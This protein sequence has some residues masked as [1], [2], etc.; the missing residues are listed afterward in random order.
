[1]NLIVHYYIAISVSYVW[2]V[3][4][5]KI[6]TTEIQILIMKTHYNLGLN[7]GMDQQQDHFKNAVQS[8]T[9]FFIWLNHLKKMGSVLNRPQNGPS[10]L[11]W[12]KKVRKHYTGLAQNL[13]KSVGDCFQSTMFQTVQFFVPY[14]LVSL[15]LRCC[16]WDMIYN[17]RW[18]S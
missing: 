10:K 8:R 18:V 6:L 13:S 3:S 14:N 2:I 4:E 11:Y 1:M 17:W 5:C 7:D 9:T 12:Q 16:I 15:N